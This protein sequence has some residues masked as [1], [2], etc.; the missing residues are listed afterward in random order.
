MDRGALVAVL[1]VVIGGMWWWG[2]D[3]GQIFGGFNRKEVEQRLSTLEADAAKFRS[4]ATE[5]R[6]RNTTLESELAMTRGTQEALTR[7]AAETIR[8]ERPAEGRT[9]VPAEA[10][11]DSNK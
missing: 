10:R 5:L 4:E 11:V 8:R 3:F 2:Y 1:L 9:R 7:Q 6:A